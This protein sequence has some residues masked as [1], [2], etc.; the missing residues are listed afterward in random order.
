MAAPTGKNTMK[1]MV[2]TL[3]KS[4]NSSHLDSGG[5]TRDSVWLTYRKPKIPTIPDIAPPLT[6]Y[7]QLCHLSFCQSII[8]EAPR[9]S[10][11]ELPRTQ[12]HPSQV[13]GETFSATSPLPPFPLGLDCREATTPHRRRA[14]RRRA[15]GRT[16]P[17][18]KRD[19]VLLII[20][21][22]S[23]TY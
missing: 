21:P 22:H 18:S 2:P 8:A 20:V 10:R 19:Q 3:A 16:F 7:G 5:P 4:R 17:R 11:V 23:R 1:N 6:Q 15:R 9:T 13:T 12:S 14:P